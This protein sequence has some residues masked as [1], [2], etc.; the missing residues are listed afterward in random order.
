MARGGIGVMAIM[1]DINLAAQYADRIMLLKEGRMI[2]QG[3]PREV[4]T[5]TLIWDTFAFGVKVIVHPELA[6]PLVVPDGGF[7]QV[8]K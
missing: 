4:L 7:T 5:S 3:S 1:H 2:G 6:I 8:L